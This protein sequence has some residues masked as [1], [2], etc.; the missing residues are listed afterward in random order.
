MTSEVAMAVAICSSTWGPRSSRSTMPMPPV[1]TTST[2]RSPLDARRNAGTVTR[3]RVTPAVGSTIE[4]RLPHM[5]FASVDLPTFGRPM[6]AIRGRRLC[7][8]VGI[9]DAFRGRAFAQNGR[10]RIRERAWMD[11]TGGLER[12]A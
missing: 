2:Q 7:A 4:T 3:S 11:N 5:R 8:A 12:Q 9:G 10:R 1:S 6:I